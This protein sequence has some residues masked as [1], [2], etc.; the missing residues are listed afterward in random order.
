MSICQHCK[1]QPVVLN[2]RHG[3]LCARCWMQVLTLNASHFCEFS[4]SPTIIAERRMLHDQYGEAEVAEYYG[5]KGG[6]EEN[7][8]SEN[9]LT[10]YK[11]PYYEDHMGDIG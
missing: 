9:G 3:V 7:D 5:K 2:D 1:Q 4:I 10:L 6:D 8:Q 11:R